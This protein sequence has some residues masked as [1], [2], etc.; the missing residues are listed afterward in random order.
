SEFSEIESSEQLLRAALARQPL[1]LGQLEEVET[2][3][4][5]VLETIDRFEKELA[6][7]SEEVNRLKS[8]AAEIEQELI[9]VRGSI[10]SLRLEQEVPTEQDLID[11]R[12]LRDEGWGLVRK[13]LEEGREDA[14]TVARFAASVKSDGTLAEVYELSVKQAD[15]IADRLRREADRVAAKAKL[16]ADEQT[17][18]TQLERIGKELAEATER[19]ARVDLEWSVLWQDSGITPLTPREMRSWCQELKAAAEEVSKLRV[20]RAKAEALRTD[21]ERRGNDLDQSL[22]ALGEPAAAAGETLQDLIRRCQRVIRRQEELG[23]TKEQLLSDMKTLERHIQEARAKAEG[24]DSDLDQ[25]QRHWQEAVSP[26][27]LG[28][29]ATPGQASAFIEGLKELFDKLREAET[30]QKRIRGIDRDAEKFSQDLGELAERVAP[31]L[32]ALKAERQVSELNARLK[33]AREGK[34]EKEGLQKQY[35]RQIQKLKET[36]KT[37]SEVGAELASM[38]KEAGCESYDELAEAERRSTIKLKIENELEELEKQLRKL[39]GGATVDEF[40]A[41]A[42][43]EDPDTLET[44]IERLREEGEELGGERSDLDQAIGRAR[45][46]LEGMKGSAS[47]ADLAEKRQQL[48]GHLETAVEKYVRLRLASAVLARTI[49]QYREKHQGPILER[50]NELFSRL[51][52]GSFEGVRAEYNQRGEPVLMGVRPGGRELIGVEGMSD[53][54]TDQLYLALRL[55]SLEAYLQKSEPMPFIVDDILIRFD[56]NR[57]QAALEI[58]GEIS[59]KTQVIFFTHHSH[60]VELAE[61]TLGSGVFRCFLGSS[62]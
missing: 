52:L 16:L 44:R 42:E 26:L 10:E 5:P 15:E 54:T 28:G 47:A 45:T 17:K 29:E 51:T 57:A 9:A 27:G 20:R 7:A 49:E 34:T 24:I 31:E 61:E 11:A 58:L 32:R 8:V 18:S 46:V 35:E 33:R 13:A 38:C 43:Q 1:R 22:Q 14:E 55:A 6:E 3:K 30:I 23:R 2:L 37:I 21:I 62:N 12:K 53:G 25:W 59:H 36:Q 39:G 40:V 50:T 48:L 60:L 4:I 56:N 19:L 41:M